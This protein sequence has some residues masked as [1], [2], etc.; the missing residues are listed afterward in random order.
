MKSPIPARWDPRMGQ[1]SPDFLSHAQASKPLPA[2]TTPSGPL[3]RVDAVAASQNQVQP[4][5]VIQERKASNAVRVTVNA[6]T[7]SV[8][9]R[10]NCLKPAEVSMDARAANIAARV[11]KCGRPTAKSSKATPRPAKAPGRY[12]DHK[13]I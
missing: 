7:P 8:R 12:K 11:P 2:S 6:K 1:R 5:P 9:A 3:V 4:R 13:L 10:P